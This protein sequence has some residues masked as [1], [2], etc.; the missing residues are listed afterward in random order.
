MVI[1]IYFPAPFQPSANILLAFQT[2]T[3]H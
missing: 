2:N 1:S 3:D